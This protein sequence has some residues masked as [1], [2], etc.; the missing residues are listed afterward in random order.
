MERGASTAF[1]LL[2]LTMGSSETIVSILKLLVKQQGSDLM[3]VA[4]ISQILFVGCLLVCFLCY[5][6]ATMCIYARSSNSE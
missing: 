6:V 3:Y 1:V 5:V 4:V 2:P